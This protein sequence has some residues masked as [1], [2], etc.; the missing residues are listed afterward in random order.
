MTVTSVLVPGR[1]RRPRLAGCGSVRPCAGPHRRDQRPGR[2]LL[3]A[4]DLRGVETADVAQD[5]RRLDAMTT[6]WVNRFYAANLG[7]LVLIRVGE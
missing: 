6:A 3:D 4:E 2:P 5:D 7:R 1:W